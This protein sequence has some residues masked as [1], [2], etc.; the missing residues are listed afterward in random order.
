MKTETDAAASAMAAALESAVSTPA[1][2]ETPLL[3]LA[4]PQ[5]GETPDEGVPPVDEGETEMEEDYAVNAGS[6]T[7]TINGVRIEGSVYTND[8]ANNAI[9]NALLGAVDHLKT[10]LPEAPGG[11]LLYTSMRA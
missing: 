11:C 2:V 5:A 4:A 7:L 1:P 8:T 3:A 10:N 6:A 9:R